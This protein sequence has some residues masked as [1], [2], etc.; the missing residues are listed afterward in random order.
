MSD[1]FFLETQPVPELCVCQQVAS[2]LENHADTSVSQD[3]KPNT[4]TCQ[5]LC[6]S[7]VDLERLCMYLHL[8]VSLLKGYM[9]E[10]YTTFCYIL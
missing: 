4:L 5:T 7:P 2:K 6:M 3:L 9:V 10:H 1:I 8:S